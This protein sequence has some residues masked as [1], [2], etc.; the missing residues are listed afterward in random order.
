M[1]NS[2]ILYTYSN[3]TCFS[4][5][6]HRRT[7]ISTATP[8]LAGRPRKNSRVSE[9]GPKRQNKRLHLLQQQSKQHCVYAKLQEEKPGLPTTVKHTQICLNFAQQN[10]SNATTHYLNSK[11]YTYLHQTTSSYTVFV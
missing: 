4:E 11:N 8:R 5:I 3:V 7:G 1:V 10:A 6:C 2:Y 9:A